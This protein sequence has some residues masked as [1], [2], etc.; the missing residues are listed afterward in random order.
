MAA[1]MGPYVEQ[2]RVLNEAKSLWVTKLSLRCIAS[3]LCIAVIGTGCATY[4]IE[5]IL[6]APVSLHPV[7]CT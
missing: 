6:A 1:A 3:A 2:P 7:V 4:Y 5:I